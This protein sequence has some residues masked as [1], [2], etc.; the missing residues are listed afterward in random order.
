[1]SM[2][3]FFLMIRRPPRSTLF[4]TRR[5]SDLGPPLAHRFHHARHRSGTVAPLAG[6]FL[7][8]ARSGAGGCIRPRSRNPSRLRST[9]E[10]FIVP[11]PAPQDTSRKRE[12]NMAALSIDSQRLWKSLMDLARIG[13]TEKGGVR[14]LALTR[15][16]GEARD[17][18]IRWCKEAG[19]DVATDGIGNIFARH[20]SLPPCTSE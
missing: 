6:G 2:R 5:S 9:N 11:P 4:P 19:C 17:L 16:D 10:A 15:L 8:V 12:A 13:A 7:Q 18:F 14:R 3:F 1:M 20:R